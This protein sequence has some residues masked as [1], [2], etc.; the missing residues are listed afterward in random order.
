MLS[1]KHTH[2]GPGGFSFYALTDITTFGFNEQNWEAIVTGLTMSIANAHKSI[3]SGGRVLINHGDLDHSNISRP[4]LT[5][6]R[7]PSA[8]AN[9]PAAER[10]KYKFNTGTFLPPCLSSTALPPLLRSLPDHNMTVLRLEDEDGNDIGHICWFAVHGTSMNNKNR[11]VSG[12]NKGFA[13]YSFEKAKNPPGTLPGTGQY[14]AAFGQSNEGDVSPNTKGAFCNN[15]RAC[16]V[17]HSTCGGTSENCHGYGPGKDDFASA[18]IIGTYQYEKAMELHESASVL[19]SGPLAYVHTYGRQA[20]E[21]SEHE[22][23]ASAG[24]VELDRAGGH[25]LPRR[26]GRRNGGRHHRR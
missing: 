22:R 17:A 16:E 12:D 13:S 6:D 23:P 1:A 5:P 19:L 20:S 15:G 3:S 24:T 26:P 9:N 2:S 18:R 21:A 14:V 25:D 11:L 10:A 8:Y 4:S 7:S